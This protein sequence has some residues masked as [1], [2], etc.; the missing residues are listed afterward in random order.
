[1]A[2]HGASSRMYLNCSSCSCSG[3]S[4]SPRSIPPSTRCRLWSGAGR[5]SGGT[6]CPRFCAARRRRS[7]RAC[8]LYSPHVTKEAISARVHDKSSN[9]AE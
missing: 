5:V 9:P 8:A 7:C 4:P 3:A 2:E 6:A 1:M